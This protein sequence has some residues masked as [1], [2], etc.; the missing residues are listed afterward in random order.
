MPANGASLK[1]VGLQYDLRAFHSAADIG[2][3]SLPMGSMTAAL[4]AG[5]AGIPVIGVK[6][7]IETLGADVAPGAVESIFATK[8]EFFTMLDRLVKDDAFRSRQ[9]SELK[10]AIRHNH[11]LGWPEHLQALYSQLPDKH[12]PAEI[13]EA[14]ETEA[15]GRDT[16]WFYF[17]HRS[18]LSYSSFG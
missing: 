11:C 17:Q 15:T 4:E 12:H 1:A 7:N 10:A 5:V 18:G 3:V 6:V 2:L 14:G 16:C 13:A 8:E 9:G